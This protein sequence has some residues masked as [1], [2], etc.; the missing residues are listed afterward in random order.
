MSRNVQ[1]TA[2][3]DLWGR[4]SRD[5]PGIRTQHYVELCTP[6]SVWPKLPPR[7]APGVAFGWKEPL[8][9]WTDL[10][11]CTL[12]HETHGPLCTALVSGALMNSLHTF[13]AMDSMLLSPIYCCTLPGLTQPRRGELSGC[14]LLQLQ[15]MWACKAPCNE[16]ACTAVPSPKQ[17]LNFSQPS[18]QRDWDVP[19]L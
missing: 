6:C 3:V 18:L 7:P 8:C 1:Q 17:S 19:Y 15:V 13:T 16:H 2:L 9:H 12:P 14:S 11:F 5:W 10:A 4:N